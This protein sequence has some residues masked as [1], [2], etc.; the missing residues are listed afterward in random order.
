VGRKAGVDIAVLFI[1]LLFLAYLGD[2]IY[3]LQKHVPLGDPPLPPSM[4]VGFHNI[5]TNNA[6]RAGCAICIVDDD[7]L[8]DL[9]LAVFLCK[10]KNGSRTIISDPEIR[11]YGL[12]CISSITK[13]SPIG[14]ITT[15]CDHG[16]LIISAYMRRYNKLDIYVELPVNID[17]FDDELQRLYILF[18]FWDVDD[19]ISWVA[20]EL[21][22]MNSVPRQ[23]SIFRPYGK[24][25]YGHP[26]FFWTI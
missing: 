5:A 22:D 6:Y 17:K 16:T 19:T 23:T 10:F 9:K 12:E 13:F 8:S 1:I 14:N 3:M 11:G 18:A 25:M 24:L 26:S 15:E 2:S 4:S 7:D 21:G 20:L